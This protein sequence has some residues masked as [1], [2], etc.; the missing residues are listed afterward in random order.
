M[1]C[2]AGGT[3]S[4]ITPNSDGT[5]TPQPGEDGDTISVTETA[6]NDNDDPP[7]Q[8]TVTST[9]VAVILPAPTYSSAPSL[10][11]NA[12]QGGTL[13][14]ST[15][16]WSPSN[17]A[18]A[19]AYAWYDCTG[20]G[21]SCSLS[22]TST[23]SNSYSVT[24]ADAG[25]EIE[26]R[27]TGSNDGG[28]ATA[29]SNLASASVGL[30]VNTTPPSITEPNLQVGS[31][32][33]IATGT[34]VWTNNPTLTYAWMRCPS[35]GTCTSTGGT[36]PTYVL[37][38]ADVGDTIEVIVTATNAAVTSGGTAAP[39]ATS[40]PTG[41]VVLTA[42][43]LTASPTISGTAPGGKSLTLGAARF[44]G[45]SLTI[46]TQWLLCAS[47]GSAC[48]PIASA[49]GTQYT[50]MPTDVGGTLQVTQVAT[51]SGGSATGLSGL[52]DPV[53]NAADV[54]PA[55]AL[56]AGGPQISGTAQVGSTVTATRAS[57]S[58]NPGTYDYQWQR[59]NATCTT[60]PNATS[61]SYEPTAAD[62]GYTLQ[63][64]ESAS[65]TG[66]T[67]ASTQSP[68]TAVVTAPTTTILQSSVRRPVAGQSVSLIAAVSSPAP[69][70]EA[71]TITF[72]INGKAIPG[73]AGM[74]LPADPSQPVICHTVFAAARHVVVASFT[75]AS[76]TYVTGSASPA[77]TFAVRRVATTITL[78]NGSR[79]L[80][81][82][83]VTYRA[84]V[85]PGSSGSL[86]PAGRVA[87]LDGTKPIK[88]CA[89]QRLHNAVA[90]C[91]IRYQGLQTH[92]ISVR[93]GGD[94]DFAAAR[95]P[96]RHIIVAAQSPA[97]VVT[98]YMSWTFAY[99][100]FGTMVRK[101]SI[102]GLVRG[103]RISM[104]C[105]GGGCPFQNYAKTISGP[106][107]CK[108]HHRCRA[109]TSL[110]LTHAFRRDRL[111]VG[112]HLTVTLSHRDWVGKYY[113][114]TI[115][116]SRQPAL[117]E[118]CLAAGGTRPSVGC[119]AGT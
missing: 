40:A 24:S 3:C 29:D 97:G 45:S 73:C 54:V 114:F 99:G 70:L 43:V 89:H 80:L 96:L 16:T 67:S 107:H 115:R 110:N 34:D 15:G 69:S 78:G 95:S 21:A 118:S 48:Q 13:T 79:V 65:N 59:C 22:P 101:L 28:S 112:A 102:A 57:F 36:G 23:N 82:K 41:A 49:T 58:G 91:T 4:T 50:V 103:T 77:T 63:I 113:R 105:S 7:T 38:S 76:G 44:S 94:A 35:G 74:A 33:S 86:K 19:Y 47:D 75:P 66:G 72:S 64:V 84:T 30:P 93:Y 61:L 81:G 2:T 39:T 25:Y 5:Y 9:S 68:N 60:I 116:H 62:A 31:T 109:A 26:A 27:V 119:S 55:P 51:N 12:N 42:P 108:A 8:T 90:T 100:P 117:R 52:T 37:A 11:G 32:L 104:V 88:G 6:S 85:Q 10:T 71:G 53:T 111:R 14:V 20:G 56:T 83:N 18:P 92:T 106:T 87:F 46:T 17:P 98:A 1:E